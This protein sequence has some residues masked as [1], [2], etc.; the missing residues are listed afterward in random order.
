M[1]GFSD[2][3]IAE[4]VDRF[5]LKQITVPTLKTGA[6]DIL[7]ARDRVYDLLTTAL[8]LR[9]DS[10]FYV[11]YLARNRLM[12]LV[13]QQIALLDTIVA[14]APNATRAAKLIN[15]TTDLAA[16]Q[17][18]LLDLNAGL[19][20]RSTGVRGSI[21]PAVDRFRRSI[22]SFVSEELTKNT[23]VSGQV[24]E[25]GPEL[26]STIASAW[27]DIVDRH[28]EIVRLATNL[29]GALTTLEGVRLPE[30][31]VRDIVSRIQ[32]RLGEVKAV[33]EGDSAIEQSRSAMLDLL[34]MRTLLTRASTFRNPELVLMPKTRDTAS[35]A[36]LD[37]DGTQ[38]RIQGTI[39]GPFN[40]DPGAA[41]TLSVNGGTPVVVNLPRTTKGSRAELRSRVFSPWVAPTIGHEMSFVLDFSL[42]TGFILPSA[43]ASGPLAAAAFNAALAPLASCTW[44]ATTNQL[45]F[46]SNEE[47]DES[48]L[49]L[50]TGTVA[51]QGFR[52]WAFPATDVPFIENKGEP[53]P[54]SEILSAIALASPL[55]SAD[56]VENNL[57]AFI[58]ERTSA[59]GEQAMIWNRLDQ[60]NDLVSIGTTLV[61]SPSRNFSTLGIRPGMAL[62]TTAPGVADYVI[63]QVS[64]NELV[65]GSPPPLGALTY[66]IGP[67]YRSITPGARVQV[68]SGA[69]RD[70]NG[71][72][73]VVTGDVARITVDRS[74]Q[75]ADTQLSV[76]VFEQFIGIEAVG[77]STSAGIGAVAGAG[78]TSLGL[79]VA[80]ETRPL[81][82]RL[83]L[84]GSGDFLLRGVRSGDLVKL[85]APSG[86]EY[87]DV[88][89]A[90]VTTTDLIIEQD[91]I[92]YEPGSWIYEVRSY[93]ADQFQGVQE[94][95]NDFLITEFV[96]NFARIDG[97]VGRLIRGARYSG[98]IVT[99]IG[100]YRTDLSAFYQ[101]LESYS[102]PRERTI[103]NVVL[104]MREQGLDRAIDLFLTLEIAEL[105][106]MDADG[107]SYNTW[108]VRKAATVAREVVPVSKYARSDRVVQEW[109][110]VS[111]Q[112]N[113]FDPR[114]GD[115]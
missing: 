24:T 113:P 100:S 65:L 90:E 29:A 30:T 52:D 115:T 40:Y 97:L 105:F 23:V 73:R 49:R 66:Y 106:S 7:T 67:D 57:A 42:V 58:G 64:D 32:T 18:A 89:I 35:V 4:A 77:T 108:L 88:V 104:T 51:Q 87:D 82:T 31:S 19:N 21:G 70:N 93:R 78:A 56:I 59:G 12:A 92:V 47:N 95:A 94:A 22:S 53:V 54:S 86:V 109:R 33:M 69:N 16:A 63:E 28:P 75:F 34:T 14:A 76:S 83:R 98:E 43:Y 50:R 2:E 68:V 15:S 80:A 25:T 103:D 20:S 79:V 55:V 85:T 72:Y 99:A 27:A 91:G 39:S 96:T 60:G 44:D 1:A 81:L 37:S 114:G 112:P 46:Q 8:L 111:Y 26:R 5:L 107:V 13:S 48:H 10:Y 41:L 6:R 62:H 84:V 102:I 17:A 9:P 3:E 36:F 45:V 11:T 38:A 110:A 101:G 71:F 61:T 74:L